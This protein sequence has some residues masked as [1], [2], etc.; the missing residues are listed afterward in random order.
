M[1]SSTRSFNKLR[2]ARKR[3]ALYQEEIAFLL[4]SRDGARVSRYELSARTPLL[5]TAVA[6][7][8]IYQCPIGELFTGLKEEVA[9]D[10]GKRARILKHRISFRGEGRRMEKRRAAICALINQ[11]K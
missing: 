6:F 8:L 11:N 4:G 2:A 5:R 9:A 7:E 1:P 10:V 3:L